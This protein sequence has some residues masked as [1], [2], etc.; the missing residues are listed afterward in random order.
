M[1]QACDLV[2]CFDP[3]KTQRGY[4]QTRGRARQRKSTYVIM[5]EDGNDL[6]L[7][8]YEKFRALEQSFD[9]EFLTSHNTNGGSPPLIDSAAEDEEEEEDP[10]DVALRES[11]IVRST[12]ATLTYSSAIAILDHLCALIP[13]DAYTSALRPIYEGE[14]QVTVRLPFAIPLPA[15][16][17]VIPGKPRRTKKEAKKSAAFC[18]ARILHKLG[19]LDDHLLPTKSRSARVIEDADDRK[20]E[21]FDSVSD[22]MDVM[23]ASPWRAGPPWFLYVVQVNAST[24]AGLISGHPFPGV[25]IVYRGQHVDMHCHQNH[26]ISHIDDNQ[27]QLLDSFT[28]CGIWWNVTASP[29]QASPSCFLCPLDEHLKI[30]WAAMEEVASN[31]IGVYDWD[32]I[33]EEDEGCVMLMNERKYGRPL[34][35]LRFRSDLTMESRPPVTDDDTHFNTFAEYFEHEHSVKAS[36][37]EKKLFEGRPPAGRL[38]EVVPWARWPSSN[39]SSLYGTSKKTTTMQGEKTQP[40]FLLPESFCRRALLSKP[41]L[42]AFHVFAPLCQRICDVFRSQ[43]IQQHL[44][45]PPMTADLVIEATTIPAAMA[46]FNNQRLETMGDSVLKLG[47]ITYIFNRFPQKHEGQLEAIKSNSVCNRFLFTRAR[48]IELERFISCEN[49][50]NRAWFFTLPEASEASDWITLAGTIPCVKRNFARRSL[51]DCMEAILGAAY[52]CGGIDHAL[53]AGDALGLCFGGS[54][55][56]RDR[57]EP[58]KNVPPAPLFTTLQQ[59]LGYTFT[60]GALLV[61]AVKHPSFDAEGGPSYQRLEFLGDGEQYLSLFFIAATNEGCHIAVIELVVTTY[62]FNKYRDATSGTLSW[63]R[64]RAICNTTLGA[65]AVKRLSLHKYLLANSVLLFKELSKEVP[66]LS[67]ASY[68]DL[69]VNGWRY[70]P[71]KVLADIFEGLVGAMFVDSGHDYLRV[72]GIIENIMEDVLVRLN[73]DIPKDP[74]SML[75]QWTA[76]AGCRNVKFM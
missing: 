59:E 27:L 7:K 1:T 73:E 75:L 13:R 41:L 33:R 16:Y 42:D 44:L 66:L 39:Y 55:P 2:I 23:V 5:I 76:K 18:A 10:Q 74:T 63:V 9:T 50:I 14:F 37:R 28:K 22:M 30:D 26:I 6:D 53:R 19:V 56:W 20:I 71:P 15:E 3:P 54:R 51:Q 32:S 4:I 60:N 38:L 43:T 58:A 24:S 48:A 65:V 64:A 36:K 47:V 49:R 67:E 25:S 70:D 34:R 45:L 11:Y 72:A 35:F 57:Y 29:L 31:K 61:E 68:D 12:G 46:N 62:L 17:Q 52:I 69:V 8:R 40:P 21:S